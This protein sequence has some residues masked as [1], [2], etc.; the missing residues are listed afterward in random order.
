MNEAWQILIIVELFWVMEHKESL[1][2][3]LC[4]CVCFAIFRI[5]YVDKEY[6]EMFPDEKR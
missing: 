6:E 2:C 4:F 5:K 1:H 3:S